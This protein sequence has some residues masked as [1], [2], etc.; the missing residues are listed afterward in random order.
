MHVNEGAGTESRGMAGA[1]PGLPLLLETRPAARTSPV[2]TGAR[3]TLPTPSG[4]SS[5]L[6]IGKL[7]HPENCLLFKTIER[8]R[9][10]GRGRPSV[11]PRCRVPSRLD[12]DGVGSGQRDAARRAETGKRRRQSDAMLHPV[13]AVDGV[14]AEPAE[15]YRVKMRKPGAH[16]A[17]R[18][19]G[20]RQGLRAL[21]PAAGRCTPGPRGRRHANSDQGVFA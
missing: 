6:D 14:V 8:G 17:A 5:P 15:P 21:P 11:R 19:R 13:M 12:G 4:L 9:G 1:W 2:P 20:L 18:R 10:A 3:Q 16:R 7:S